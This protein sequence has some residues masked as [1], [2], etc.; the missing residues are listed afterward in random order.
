M[1]IR[2]SNG[3]D[4]NYSHPFMLGSH[5]SNSL[6]LGIGQ[7]KGLF[8]ESQPINNK[9]V[10][11]GYFAVNRM[12][13]IVGTLLHISIQMSRNLFW[14]R[15][16]SWMTRQGIEDVLASTYPIPE[17]VIGVFDSVSSVKQEDAPGE[18]PGAV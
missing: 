7:R 6:L 14:H 2:L 3:N 1:F 8:N 16:P 10:L 9:A 12:F 18:V 4:R 17:S 13:H 15:G 5:Q 11:K